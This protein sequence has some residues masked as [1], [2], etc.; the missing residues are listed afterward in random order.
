[1]T[2]SGCIITTKSGDEFRTKTRDI[3]PWTFDTYV[4]ERSKLIMIIL[5]PGRGS[6]RR[7]SGTAYSNQTYLLPGEEITKHTS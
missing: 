7:N 1:M 4:E 5:I 6:K 2:E 3:V